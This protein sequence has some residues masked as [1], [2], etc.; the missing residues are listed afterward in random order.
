MATRARR[1]VRDGVLDR[2]VEETIA[3]SLASRAHGDAVDIEAHVQD[4]D[5]APEAQRNRQ[6]MIQDGPIR[7]GSVHAGDD[8][9][10][11]GIL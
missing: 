4:V 7:L 10:D 11:A 5:V 6:C 3:V 2:N 8:L 1:R 9:L